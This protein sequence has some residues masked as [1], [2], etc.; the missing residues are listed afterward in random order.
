MSQLS[1]SIDDGETILEFGDAKS[2]RNVFSSIGGSQVTFFDATGGSYLDSI[3]FS[4]QSS[5]RGGLARFG[6][7]G[8]G[9]KRFGVGRALQIK[10]GAV[11][12]SITVGDVVLGGSGGSAAVSG[13]SIPPFPG[14]IIINEVRRTLILYLMPLLVQNLKIDLNVR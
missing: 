11:L 13:V 8:G 10:S 12:N 5:L 2:A 3:G 6:G 7:L 9:L 1:F 4:F 14:K